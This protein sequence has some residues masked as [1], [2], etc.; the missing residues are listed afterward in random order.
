M[1]SLNWLS[2]HRNPHVVQRLR[3]NKANRQ[4]ATV[5]NVSETQSP[6][7]LCQLAP[8]TIHI[9]IDALVIGVIVSPVLYLRP[10]SLSALHSAAAAG[11]PLVGFSLLCRPRLPLP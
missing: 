7:V 3:Q 9:L 1:M 6:P 11:K 4:N 2:N 10:C 5:S 8:D